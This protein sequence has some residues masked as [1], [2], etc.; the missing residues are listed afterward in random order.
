MGLQEEQEAQGGQ[1]PVTMTLPYPGER[2]VQG[3]VAMMAVREQQEKIT[4]VAL[5]DQM[6]LP[7]VVGVLEEPAVLALKIVCFAVRS[8]AM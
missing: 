4:R 8:A 6:A 7:E 5:Q 3:Q 2:E 1:V